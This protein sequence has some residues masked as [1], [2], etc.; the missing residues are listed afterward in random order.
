MCL[1]S[2]GRAFGIGSMMWEKRIKKLHQVLGWHSGW[3]LAVPPLW[4][5]V[6]QWCEQC[7]CLSLQSQWSM[8]GDLRHIS[9][10]WSRHRSGQPALWADRSEGPLWMKGDSVYWKGPKCVWWCCWVLRCLTAGSKGCRVVVSPYDSDSYDLLSL[11]NLPF[12][13]FF[14]HFPIKLNS[15]SSPS[16]PKPFTQVSYLSWLAETWSDGWH[17]SSFP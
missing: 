7:G 14:Y 1:K 10:I 13:L 9:G 6:C 5:V 17:T 11:K 8:P 3:Q 2:L 15:R 12:L 16:Q 4:S